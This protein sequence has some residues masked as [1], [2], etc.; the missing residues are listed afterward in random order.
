M[1]ALKRRISVGADDGQ[2]VAVLNQEGA[3]QAYLQIHP[4]FKS[5]ESEEQMIIQAEE[6][7][8]TPSRRGGFVLWVW[9]DSADS[10]RQEILQRR[11]Y[12]TLLKP[13]NTSGES[14]SARPRSH[15]E[16]LWRAILEDSSELP[17]PQLG[18]LEAH[19]DE[20]DDITVVI[21]LGTRISD[22][23]SH[24]RDLTWWRLLLPVK[25]R[26]SAPS[27]TMT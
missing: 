3:G 18:Q 17:L 12:I 9:S 26:H 20:P 27:G 24:R 15:S 6:C 16:R 5:T 19:P 7:L 4:A 10:L 25:W 2:I 22:G 21:G 11:G 13:M 1:A 8:R 23:T 14:G